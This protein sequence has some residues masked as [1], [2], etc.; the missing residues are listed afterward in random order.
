MGSKW[1]LG[2]SVGGVGVWSGFTWLSI[3]TGGAL[4]WMRWW[5]FGFWHHAV[6][7]ILQVCHSMKWWLSFVLLCCQVCQTFIDVSQ[8]NRSPGKPRSV[9]DGRK[10]AQQNRKICMFL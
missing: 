3:G 1:T 10:T 7:Y 2:R 4:L 9:V 6:S 5:T 8:V